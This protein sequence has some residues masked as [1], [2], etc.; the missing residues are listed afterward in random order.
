MTKLILHCATSHTLAENRAKPLRVALQ[1]YL[2]FFSTNISRIIKVNG[3]NLKLFDIVNVYE[4]QLHN[5]LLGGGCQWL[6]CE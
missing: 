2:P 3:N 4:V 6:P 1:N 5:T